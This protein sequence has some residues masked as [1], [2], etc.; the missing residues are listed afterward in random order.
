MRK[1]GAL[2]LMLLITF[3]SRGS[4]ASADPSLMPELDRAPA[5]VPSPARSRERTLPP[6]APPAEE[7][8]P[9][10]TAS[11]RRGEDPSP[12]RRS[13]LRLRTRAWLTSGSID[14]RYCAQVPPDQVTPAG[15]EV[16]EGETEERGAK[17]IMLVHSMELAPLKWLSFEGQFG[18]DKAKGRYNDGIWVHA[19]DTDLLTYFPTGGTWVKPDHVDDVGYGADVS[20]RRDW[21]AA[22]VY[23][24]IVD[25]HIA[26]VDELEVRH[27]LDIALG[28]ERYRQNSRLT[29]LERTL[30]VGKRYPV[31]PLGAVAGLDSAYLAQW[32]GPHIGLRE[33]FF[34]PYGF[35]FDGT[36]L[37][38]P[39]MEYRGDGYDNLSA[40]PGGLRSE[41]PNF[42]DRAHGTAVH[43]QV[44][45]GWA[46]RNIRLEAGY[47]RLYFYSRTGMRR[48]YAFDGSSTD[49]QLEFATAELG[50]AYLGASLRF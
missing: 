29:N 30:S 14:T 4:A 43:I 44:G 16:F 8:A 45:G 21:A 11:R 5:R 19:P 20:A 35:S 10:S 13:V 38:S 33:E 7:L 42:I 32:R 39:F 40:G 50:G 36:V 22:T 31:A 37:W 6:E 27:A 34:A 24:R 47:Q 48:Y 46:W 26:E 18:E 25:A 17:G 2:V 3:P 12:P 1:V 15:M 9:S 23:L 28:V 41:A 49:Y